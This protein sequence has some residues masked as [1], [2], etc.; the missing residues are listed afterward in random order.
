MLVFL[1][2]CFHLSIIPFCDGLGKYEIVIA[3]FFAVLKE[4]LIV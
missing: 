3:L 4:S 1:K 2:N